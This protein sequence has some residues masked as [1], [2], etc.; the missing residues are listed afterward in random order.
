MENSMFKYLI[1][2]LFSFTLQATIYFPAGQQFNVRTVNKNSIQV[3]WDIH[4]VLA[5]KEKRIGKLIKHAFTIGVPYLFGNEGWDEIERVSASE[6]ISGEGQS[7]ILAKHG[8]KDLAKQVE[9]AAN[10][11]TPR[12]GMDTIVYGIHSKG[13]TPTTCFKYWPT[14]LA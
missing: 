7:T 11:Y 3:A 10:E 1:V 8:H 9:K 4:N 2:A 6:D 13:I 12:K 14:F 5:Q